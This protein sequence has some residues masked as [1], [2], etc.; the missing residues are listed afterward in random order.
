MCSVPEDVK[1]IVET[2]DG[3][4]CGYIDKND[5][6]TYYKFSGIPYAKPPLGRLRFM[7][8]H[9][10]LNHFIYNYLSQHYHQLISAHC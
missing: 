1:C 5:E 9:I 4:I 10:F 3:P 8:S 7:V 2:K 6:G